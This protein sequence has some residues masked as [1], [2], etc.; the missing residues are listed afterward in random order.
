MQEEFFDK[1]AN[2]VEKAN[3]KMRSALDDSKYPHGYMQSVP[4]LP[5]IVRKHANA[6]VAKPKRTGPITQNTPPKRL[7]TQHNPNQPNT[8]EGKGSGQCRY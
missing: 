5:D 4:T 2:D 3:R 1:A 7:Q 6:I 8:Y